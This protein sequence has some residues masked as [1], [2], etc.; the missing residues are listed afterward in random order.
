MTRR[1][2][3]RTL[4]TLLTSVALVAVLAGCGLVGGGGDSGSASGAGGRSFTVAAA[5]DILIH[6]QLI[7][8]ARADAGKT[9]EGADGLDFGPLMAGVKP[10][11][12]KADLGICHMEPVI[13]KP[14]GPFES[15]PNFLVPPQI[16]GTI[17]DVGYDTCSTASNHSIDHGY[18]GVKRTLDTLDSVGLEH[19]GSFRTEKDALTPLIIDVKGVKVAQISFAFGFNAH[20]VPKDKPWLVNQNDLGRIR[21]AEKRARAAGADVVILSIHWGREHHPNPSTPQLAFAR[22]LARETGIDLVIGHH[23][24]VVQPMEKVDG[25]WIAYGLG[26]QV[27]RHDVPTGLTEEGVIGWFTFTERG[28]RWDVEARY[29]PTLVE[30]PPDPEVGADGTP[31][32]PAKGQVEDYRLVDVAAELKRDDLSDQQRSRLRLAFERT[33]GTML[34]RGAAKDGLKPLTE[35]PG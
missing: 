15:Y 5:G 32:E 6:P 19:T 26:N 33:E 17:K 11:I 28:G 13:G 3:R 22:R 23:A 18:A 1:P 2:S 14:N 4:P 30:I 20:E 16:A 21:T 27:A 31:V 24:H 12:S 8:Q 34:N 10:V 25:T 7:D 29:E 35:L 9:G